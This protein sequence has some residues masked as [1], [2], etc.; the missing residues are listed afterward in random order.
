VLR[1]WWE[2]GGDLEEDF[3][4]EGFE[5]AHDGGEVFRIVLESGEER[6]LW[7]ALNGVTPHLRA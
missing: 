1:E 4:G 6:R 2:V 7:R 3:G 5:L